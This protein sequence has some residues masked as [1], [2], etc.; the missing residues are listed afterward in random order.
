MGASESLPASRD[1]R[2]VTNA[3]GLSR[4]TYPDGATLVWVGEV[5]RFEAPA[6]APPVNAGAVLRDA[7][8][9]CDHDVD[10]FI[11]ELNREHM[12]VS[13][14][15]AAVEG[16]QVEFAQGRLTPMHRISLMSRTAAFRD[17]DRVRVHYVDPRGRGLI[18]LLESMQR[19]FDASDSGE[20]PHPFWAYIPSVIDAV[21]DALVLSAKL[22]HAQLRKVPAANR[23][24]LMRAYDETQE[25]QRHHTSAARDSLEDG[26]FTRIHRHLLAALD[27]SMN[28]NVLIRAGRGD[29]HRDRIAFTGDDHRLQIGDLIMAAMP[30]EFSG[31]YTE[32]VERPEDDGTDV[33]NVTT[34]QIARALDT[35]LGRR[36]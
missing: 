34:A 8:R 21:E 17:C 18:D 3:L 23:A 9:R 5:H 25:I 11:E 29:L 16:K 12:P 19:E 31:A 6:D 15:T 26:R 22:S 1:S 20:P 28:V 13:E 35:E 36:R 27:V 32:L 14:A 4:V 10:L 2:P 24:F 33:A 30:D 7:L